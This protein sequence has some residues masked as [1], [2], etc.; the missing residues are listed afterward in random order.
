MPKKIRFESF[1]YHFLKILSKKINDQ[2]IK[3]F[4][5][6][7][8]IDNIEFKYLDKSVKINWEYPNSGDCIFDIKNVYFYKRENDKF[9]DIKD[10]KNKNSKFFTSCV[11]SF[12][13][14]INLNE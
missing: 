4:D 8:V 7:K 10:I 14:K 13:D 12:L 11:N 3:K 9:N 5:K 2:V 1:K 6:E